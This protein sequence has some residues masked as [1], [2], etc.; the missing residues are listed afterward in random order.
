MVLMITDGLTDERDV[1]DWASILKEYK[2]HLAMLLIKD[3][4]IYWL[5][6]NQSRSYETQNTKAVV[7][8]PPLQDRGPM[9]QDC[10]VQVD[11]TGGVVCFAFTYNF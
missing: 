6:D 2:L 1:G 5:A 10:T 3:P 7:T 9:T 11:I 8:S 4:W